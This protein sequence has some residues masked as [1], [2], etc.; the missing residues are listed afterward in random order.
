MVGG[1]DVKV[2]LRKFQQ[3]G[4]NDDE[5]LQSGFNSAREQLELLQYPLRYTTLHNKNVEQELFTKP[6]CIRLLFRSQQSNHRAST[7]LE[8]KISEGKNRQIRK[9]CAR[10]GLRVL[11]LRRLC[12]GPVQLK[13]LEPGR[14]RELTQQEL[15]DCYAVGLP[16]EKPPTVVPLPLPPTDGELSVDL[17]MDAM[18]SN[19]LPLMGVMLQNMAPEF[20]TL[21]STPKDPLVAVDRIKTSSERSD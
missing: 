9:L 11:V 20:V 12:I 8:V 1:G 17:V 3:S 14:A 21:V 10:S 13:S 15:Q 19:E 2:P 16:G 4:S 7:W 6:A 18:Q 5:E